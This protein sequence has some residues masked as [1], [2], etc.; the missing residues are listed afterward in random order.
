MKWEQGQR[1]ADWEHWGFSV[2]CIGPSDPRDVCRVGM[3]QT[4]HG[5]CDLGAV[6]PGQ[7][8]R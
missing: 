6:G 8:A 1:G 3:P 2:V 7:Q 5:R 4:L